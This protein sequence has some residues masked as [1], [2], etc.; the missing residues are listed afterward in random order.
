MLKIHQGV[1][2]RLQVSLELIF[3]WKQ[4]FALIITILSWKPIGHLFYDQITQ[5]IYFWGQFGIFVG[6]L[7]FFIIKDLVFGLGHWPLKSYSYSMIE[8][9]TFST[10]I[11]KGFIVK[12]IIC[13]K[14]KRNFV[15]KNLNGRQC[16]LFMNGEINNKILLWTKFN[17]V[18]GPVFFGT[19]FILVQ[20]TLFKAKSEFQMMTT[21]HGFSLK[22]GF[23]KIWW[24]Q[25][26][27]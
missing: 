26:M 24:P 13:W 21:K 25:N 8:W 22:S 2:I 9:Q 20:W 6:F 27:F 16:I 10:L 12:H 23:R 14:Y 3:F 5:E 18:S 17:C 19:P 7:N 4:Q 15:F 1:S 11:L